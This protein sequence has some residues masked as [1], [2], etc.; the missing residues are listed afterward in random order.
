MSLPRKIAFLVFTTLVCALVP[1]HA[2][3]DDSRLQTAA[4]ALE[5]QYDEVEARK[6]NLVTK[7]QAED[8]IEYRQEKAKINQDWITDVLKHDERSKILPGTL[9]NSQTGILSDSKK[10]ILQRNIQNYWHNP[11]S[12]LYSPSHPMYRAATLMEKAV[13]GDGLNSA[14]VEELEGLGEMI[15][16][17]I[18]DLGRQQNA[19]TAATSAAQAALNDSTFEL[20]QI[21]STGID[22][23]EF[24]VPVGDTDKIVYNRRNSNELLQKS[25]IAYYDYLKVILPTLCSLM[26]VWGG[27]DWALSGGNPERVKSGRNKIINAFAALAL[28]IVLGQILQTINPDFFGNPSDNTQQET[29]A[30]S[31]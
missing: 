17:E 12:E 31:Q 3:A 30:N 23:F 14:E 7:M 22:I 10:Q 5:A 16:Q 6:A 9:Q 2:L 25:I 21:K 8:Q 1:G 15:E 29:G 20:E 13:F 24:M 26:I 11:E 19:A 28:F 18:E 27:V 4:D